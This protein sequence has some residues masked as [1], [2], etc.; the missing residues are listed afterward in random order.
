MPD[1]QYKW[2]SDDAWLA[3]NDRFFAADPKQDRE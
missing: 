1:N 3:T 2:L